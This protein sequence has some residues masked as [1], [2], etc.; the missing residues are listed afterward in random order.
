MRDC[1]WGKKESVIRTEGE[2]GEAFMLYIVGE[3]EEDKGRE[4]ER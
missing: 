3:Q 2:N 4:R 1:V